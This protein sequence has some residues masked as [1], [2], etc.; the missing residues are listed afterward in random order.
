MRHSGLLS[1]SLLGSALLTFL[2]LAH[3]ASC[4][5]GLVAAINGRDYN[6]NYYWKR[7]PQE[8]SQQ[9]RPHSVYTNPDTPGTGPARKRS[10]FSHINGDIAA[11][12]LAGAKA[13]LLQH[14]NQ[15]PITI[16][17]HA[18]PP[19]PAPALA[20]P[21]YHTA[22]E[23][24]N[25]RESESVVTRSKQGLDIWEE[26]GEGNTLI[27]PHYRPS[28]D[29]FGEDEEDD[30]EELLELGEDGILR[31]VSRDDP[32]SR[33]S[34]LGGI[35]GNENSS[36]RK[37]QQESDELQDQVWMVDEWEEDLE[38]EMDELL[39]WADE[40]DDDEP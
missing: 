12:S 33:Y 23:G 11:A 25:G 27:E 4:G 9:P 20:P 37:E 36:S 24:Q 1:R 31:E 38:G 19:P 32:R 17:L 2:L 29:L 35:H 14:H 21:V 3:Q 22:E 30:E 6:N 40:D 10:L 18:S 28:H 15:V 34:T 16:P 8:V 7:S 26:E 39:C 5:N 13:A